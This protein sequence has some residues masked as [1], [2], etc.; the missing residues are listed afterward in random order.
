MDLQQR[1]EISFMLDPAKNAPGKHQIV[2]LNNVIR[3][4]VVVF[5][6]EMLRAIKC[7]LFFR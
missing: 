2:L 3:D 1:Y 4:D 6:R 5:T 7:N